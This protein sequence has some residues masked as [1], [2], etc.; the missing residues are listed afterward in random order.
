MRG[1]IGGG[2]S[3]LSAAY[4]LCDTQPI[5]LFTNA[6]TGGWIKSLQRHGHLFELGPRTLRPVG[7]PG[8]CTLGLISE[9]K[10]LDQLLLVSKDSPAAQNRFLYSHSHLQALPSSLLSLIKHRPRAFKGILSSFL[11]EPF[12]TTRSGLLSLARQSQCSFCI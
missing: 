1:I 3:G 4:H 12:T 8:A 10:L 6:Q 7:L 9:L 2:I 5:T 11:K